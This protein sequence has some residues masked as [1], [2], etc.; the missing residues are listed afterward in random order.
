MNL[1]SHQGLSNRTLFERPGIHES[2]P[3]CLNKIHG[4]IFLLKYIEHEAAFRPN[5][6]FQKICLMWTKQR[7]FGMIIQ[8]TMAT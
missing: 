2:P 8:V 6:Y 4:I 5:G 1:S 7:Q 3:V